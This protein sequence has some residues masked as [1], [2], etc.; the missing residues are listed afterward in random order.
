MFE[1]IS[2]IFIAYFLLLLIIYLGYKKS[3]TLSWEAF[4]PVKQ[5]FSILIPY[6]NEEKNLL[7][8]IKSLNNLNYLPEDFEVLFIN[9]NST[10]NGTLLIKEHINIPHRLLDSNKPCASPKKEALEMG[11]KEA[12]F[13][14]IITT[15]ADCEVPE[16]W[17]QTYNLLIQDKKP[18]MILG[19][20]KYKN[21]NTFIGQFQIIEFLSLQAFTIGSLELGFP[22][23]S[24]AANLGF[25]KEFFFMLG[26]YEGNKHIASGDDVFLLE[27]FNNA[28]PN[29]IYYL[30]SKEAIVQTGAQGNWHS[31]FN[32]KIRWASKSKEIKNR[33]GQISG[34]IIVLTNLF[35]LFMYVLIWFYPLF[36]ISLLGTKFLIDFLVVNHTKKFFKNTINF[37][38]FILSF[39]TYPLYLIILLFG[40]TQKIYIWKGNKYNT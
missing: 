39:F 19:P 37:F 32:Q 15:D 2:G 9:N 33:F 12:K 21:D 16:K 29:D 18:K 25:E 14:F 10:D 20:V 4:P 23:L 1:L 24:N 22:F 28:Y 11:I 3:K 6:K 17:L 31:L 27:K 8:L 5:K 34:A 13:D 26:G 38:Y 30:K 35:T 40:L 7:P 36:S